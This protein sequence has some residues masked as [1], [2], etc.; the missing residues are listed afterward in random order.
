MYRRSK[1]VEILTEIREEMAQESDYDVVLFAEMIRS[2]GTDVPVR[3][4]K[5]LVIGKPEA[6]PTNGGPPLRRTDDLV[7]K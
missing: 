7:G 6:E 1:F 5:R 4:R 3:D 2:G